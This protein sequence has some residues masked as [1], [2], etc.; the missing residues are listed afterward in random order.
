MFLPCIPHVIPAHCMHRWHC[1]AGTAILYYVTLHH[2]FCRH[3]IIRMGIWQ[4]YSYIT[5]Q[6]AWF[7]ESVNKSVEIFHSDGPLAGRYL[8]QYLH[9]E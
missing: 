5:G 7:C 3:C 8:V 9:T 4:T 2:I 1:S 6:N